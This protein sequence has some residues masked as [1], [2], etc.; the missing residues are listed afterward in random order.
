MF[1]WLTTYYE[2]ELFCITFFL[3]LEPIFSIQKLLHPTEGHKQEKQNTLITV[4]TC[5]DDK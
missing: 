5:L 1:W 3:A 4:S 2:R